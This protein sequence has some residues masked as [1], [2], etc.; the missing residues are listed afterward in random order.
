MSDLS[1][2]TLTDD[3]VHHLATRIAGR[4]RE[5]YDLDDALGET[6]RERAPVRLDLPASDEGTSVL[7]WIV[8]LALVAG[9]G[10]AA[11]AAAK[12]FLGRD[13]AGLVKGEGDDGYRVDDAYAPVHGTAG[14][15]MPRP[16]SA[17][18]P[19][20]SSSGASTS[21]RPTPAG[22]PAPQ[23]PPAASAS[24]AARATEVP[25]PS[26]PPTT[27]EPATPSPTRPTPAKPEPSTPTP[28]T[29]EPPTKPS[30]PETPTTP[31]TPVKPAPGGG[32]TGNDGGKKDAGGSGSKGDTSK[33]GGDKPSA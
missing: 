20:T 26:E 27:P 13:L 14:A 18:R 19:A 7:G 11:N 25:T 5:G 1:N 30:T 17:A 8:R 31:S 28:S 10:F 33:K 23:T 4:L 6:L 3:Y 9:V 12:A 32:T 29:P 24:A 22:A 2:R 15:E 21:E 16:P